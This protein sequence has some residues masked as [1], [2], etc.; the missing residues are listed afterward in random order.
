MLLHAGSPRAHALTQ[1]LSIPNL[2]IPVHA[3]YGMPMSRSH[4][5]ASILH[6]G[7]SFSSLYGNALLPGFPESFKNPERASTCLTL[8]S[9]QTPRPLNFPRPAGVMQAAAG[10]LHAAAGLFHRACLV[11]GRVLLMALIIWSTLPP[12]STSPLPPICL[13]IGGWAIECCWPFEIK[14]WSIGECCCIAGRW[15]TGGCR[16]IG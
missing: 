10:F 4:F 9:M 5:S 13:S 7:I 8:H 16:P 1:N 14:C 6:L 15:P 12:L 2:S 11:F 3:R